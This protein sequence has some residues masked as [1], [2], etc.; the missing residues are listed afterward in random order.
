MREEMKG[1]WRGRE[2][3]VPAG[4]SD[5]SKAKSSRNQRGQEMDVQSG[6]AVSFF[7]IFH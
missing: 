5:P 4:H 3:R 6:V 1:R 7:L 2:K